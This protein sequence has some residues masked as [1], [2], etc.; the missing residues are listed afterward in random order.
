MFL[1]LRILFTVLA[2]V[3]ATLVLPVGT[4]FDLGW[5]I[6]VAVLGVAFFVIMLLCKQQQE[7][8]E[9]AFE[10]NTDTNLGNSSSKELENTSE[11]TSEN[12]SERVSG[13]NLESDV[14]KQTLSN[15]LPKENLQKNT[16]GVSKNNAHSKAKN[17]KKKRK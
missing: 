2:A 4:W 1:K 12:S 16:N 14:S 9:G 6:A 3:C 10:S 11:K 15:E 8:E 5:A 7:L 17:K 13:S